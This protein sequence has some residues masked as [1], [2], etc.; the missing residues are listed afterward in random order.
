[1]SKLHIVTDSTSDIPRELA[2][3]YDI[4]IIPIEVIFEGQTYRDKQDISV[5]DLFKRI[6]ESKDF[7]KTSQPPIGEF[8][9]LYRKLLDRGGEILGIFL[10]NELS[11]TLNA[12][13]LAAEQVDSSRISIVDSRQVHW[14][15]GLQVM[16]ACEMVREGL[17]RLEIVERLQSLREKVHLLVYLDTLDFIFRGGRL[18]RLEAGIGSLLNIKPIVEVVD[19]KVKTVTKMRGK[20][21]LYRTLIKEIGKRVKPG[22]K[23]RVV[24]GEAWA[25]FEAEQLVKTLQEHFRCEMP[26]SIMGTGIGLATHVGPGVVAVSLLR[27]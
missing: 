2:E 23:I 24:V 15:L 20:K 6:P 5:D 17:S 4:N 16:K 22:E 26:Y 1:M 13:R 11:G 19:G 7:P 12:A 8:V 9:K 27:Q 3:Q 21:G 18:S 14:G 25:R 10:A